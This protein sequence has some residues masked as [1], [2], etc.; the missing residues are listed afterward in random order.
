M[1]NRG[2]SISLVG[3]AQEDGP[4][5]EISLS[6]GINVLTGKPNTGKSSWL[7][8]MDYLLGSTKETPDEA[9]GEQLATKYSTAWATV[10]LAGNSY[11][12][13]RRWKERAGK[14][15][16]WL[17]AVPIT[18]EEFSHFILQQLV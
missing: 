11:H 18:P 12:V 6:P 10:E 8:F 2:L 7:K 17:D 5:E 16:I 15:R 14:N 4:P 1:H 13:E 3:R 9:L